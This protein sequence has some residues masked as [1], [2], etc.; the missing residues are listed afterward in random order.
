MVAGG[1]R[2]DL[3]LQL[4]AMWVR[5]V[6]VERGV[7]ICERCELAYSPP[8]RL[9]GLLGRRCLEPD[10][11]LMLRPAGAVHTAF[12]R[13]SIDV[14]FL[15]RGCRVIDVRPRLRPW[16][17]AASRRSHAVL[18]LAAGESQ[19]RGLQLGERLDLV[20]AGERG[21][22]RRNGMT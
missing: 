6:S 18:E 11:G 3:G 17:A 15:D 1:S 12:M 14:V 21:A 4:Q 7:V 22:T 19:R 10:E 13:F 20:S 8:T 9:R 2:H 16:R 5:I